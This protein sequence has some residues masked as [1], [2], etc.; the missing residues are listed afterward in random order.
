MPDIFISQD[1][2]K[3]KKDSPNPITS[4]QLDT[5]VENKAHEKLPGHTHNPL[6][7][8]CY[9]PDAVDFETRDS[10]EEIILLLRM[11]PITN[12]GWI[13]IA[14]LMLLAP[15]TLRSFPILAFLPE[16]FQFISVLIWYLITTAFVI[17]SFLTWFYNVYIVTDQRV[18]DIDFYNLVYKEVSDANFDKIE[19]VTF[20]MGGVIRTLFNYGDVFIETAGEVP[21]FEFLAVPN[22]HQVVKII[23]ELIINEKQEDKERNN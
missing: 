15:L 8:Y 5:Q 19:D 12:V 7:A 13:L 21:Q 10:D 11:H 23:H 6:A 20:K 2:S 18:I 14:I 17:E 1:E 3:G 4:K 9:Y 22:P 16:N